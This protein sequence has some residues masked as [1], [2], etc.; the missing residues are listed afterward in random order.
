MPLALIPQEIDVVILC[1]GLGTRLRGIID[2]RPKVMAEINGRPFLDILIDYIK[3]YKFRRFILCV[4]YMSD[5]IK[6]YYIKKSSD[7]AILFSEEREPLGTAGAIKNA[8][9]L[10]RSEIFLVL[11][12]DSICEIDLEDFLRFHNSKKALHSIVLAAID[13][14]ADYGVIKLDENQKIIS[15]S[16]KTAVQGVSLVN[17]GIYLM[18]MTVLGDIPSGQRFS[19]EYDLLPKILDKGIYGYITDRK[20]MDIGTPE[21]L[22]LTRQIIQ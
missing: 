6:E 10:I 7:M 15:F 8:E 21:R 12:G 17:A 18:N 22:E 3:D 5:V 20:L 14:P 19:L 13:D 16:E 2:D 9:K 4:G 1:G 11:N